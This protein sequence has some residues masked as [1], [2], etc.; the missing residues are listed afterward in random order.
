MLQVQFDVNGSNRF[1]SYLNL[2]P[3]VSKEN[4]KN[5]RFTLYPTQNMYTF[6]LL[7][8]LDGRV[9]Q[10]QWS[11]EI[12]NKLIVP[13]EYELS[14]GMKEIMDKMIAGDTTQLKKN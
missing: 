5:E 13:I 8:Q 12:K 10:V 3:L 14:P 7:D 9:W 6:I 2:A 1:E 4:E 11:T